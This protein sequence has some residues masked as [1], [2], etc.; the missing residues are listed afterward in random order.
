MK[1]LRLTNAMEQC[2]SLEADNRSASQDIPHLLRYPKFH[3]RVH[4]ESA[5]EL[6]PEPVESS[7]HTL[8]PSLLTNYFNII[9]PCTLRMRRTDYRARMGK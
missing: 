7:P 2:P 1:S 5:T 4:K 8:T 9:G 3:Y 6:C